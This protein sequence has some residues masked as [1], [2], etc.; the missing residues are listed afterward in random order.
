MTPLYLREGAP[1]GEMSLFV[2]PT[3]GMAA[4]ASAAAKV[5]PVVT[6]LPPATWRAAAA[7]PASSDEAPVAAHRGGAAREF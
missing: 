5:S 4:V 6:A 2:H 7:E 3:P 1:W